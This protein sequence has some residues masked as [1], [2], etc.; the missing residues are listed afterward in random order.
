MKRPNILIILTDE[1]RFPPVYE[2]AALAEWSRTQLPAHA[3][4]R[5][6]GLEFCRHYIAASACCPS[7]ASL[8]TG[9]YPSLHGVSQTPGAAKTAFDPD[10]FWLD[11]NTVPTLGDYMRLNGYRTYYLGKWHFSNA[12]IIRPGSHLSFPSYNPATGIPDPASEQL[13]LHANR[14]DEYGFSHWVGPEPHGINPHNSGSS[15]AIGPRGRD[16]TYA[17]LFTSLIDQLEQERMSGDAART[18]AP[19]LIVTSFVNPHDIVLYGDYSTMS[20]L[21]SF[22]VAPSIPDVPYPPT[23]GETL[24]DRPRCQRSYR[25]LY[26]RAFQPISDERYYFRLY[27][28]LIKNADDQMMRVLDR[29]RRSSFYDETLIVFTA[30]HGDLLGAHGRLHQKFYCAYEEALHVPLIVHQPKLFPVPRQSELLTSHI[31]LVPTILGLTGADVTKLQA[32]LRFTHTETRPFVGRNLAD[33]FLG[34]QTVDR[35]WEPIYFMTS[36]DPTSGLHQV[37]LLGVPYPSVKGPKQIE[38][39]IAQLRTSVGEELWKYS[40]YFEPDVPD[41][42]EF[43]LYNLSADPEERINLGHPDW[44][45]SSSWQIQQ[46]MKTL[47]QE[48]AREK[49][50]TPFTAGVQ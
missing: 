43:E 5:Q 15:S 4:L 37:S 6:H 16:Q 40:R 38:T 27:Y 1:E 20:P 25:R 19:W 33:A 7:R 29:F 12:D 3:F 47:L 8:F 11:P 42:E 45:D 39:V 44:M 31:D 14:L 9:Q 34:K 23:Y 36:D 18:D 32:T 22:P 28:Q 30:D 50:L 10:Q 13:Y 21:F 46:I 24:A 2:S 48:Q 17:S 35:S 26:H 41:C 49:R